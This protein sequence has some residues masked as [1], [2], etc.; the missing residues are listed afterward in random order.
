MD[1]PR[2]PDELRPDFAPSSSP[3][4]LAES[5][6]VHASGTTHTSP[7]AL[8][9]PTSHLYTH[10]SSR[11]RSIMSG[12]NT[13]GTSRPNPGALPTHKPPVDTRFTVPT[14]PICM[15]AQ[16]CTP[17]ASRIR[18][19]ALCLPTSLPWTHDS[20]AS[21]AYLNASADVHPSGM[22]HPNPG[23]LPTQSLPGHTIPRAGTAYLHAQM[24]TP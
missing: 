15:R 18:I 22:S 1:H 3:R 14:L 17:Q 20:R 4:I 8:R 9:P 5:A 11:P 13:A 10:D 21:T 12:A 24:C 23:A 6:D 7:Q 16:M 19:P 2:R